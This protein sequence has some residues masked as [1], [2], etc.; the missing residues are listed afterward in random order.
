MSELR[1]LTHIN[2]ISASQWNALWQNTPDFDQNPFIR[3]EFLLALE[4]SGA[5]V[6]SNG[7]RAN[8]ACYWQE[9]ELLAVM[10]LYEKNHSYG[11]YVF[12]WSWADA[13]HQYGV[14]YY[15]KWVNAI[16]FTPSMGPRI[17]V[18]NPT[19]N[20][21]AM[22]SQEE[23]NRQQEITE[24]F[25]ALLIQASDK[26]NCSGIHCLFPNKNSQSAYASTVG[27][28][29]Q[30]F[31]TQFHWFN[32][33]YA[34]FDDF[35]GQL[36]SRKRKNIIKE[37]K[38]VSQSSLCIRMRDAK[39]ISEQEWQRFFA[40]YQM[41][42]LKRSGHPGYLNL[43][44]FLSLAE[45][46]SEQVLMVCAYDGDTMAAAALY[47]R[48]Q[49]TLYGRYWGALEQY[50]GLHFECCYY[51]GIEYAI[52]H[53]LQRF[54]PGAQGEHKIQRGFTPVNTCSY[55]YIAHPEFKTAINRFLLDE[56][57]HVDSYIDQCRALLPF[58]QGV[59]FMDKSHLLLQE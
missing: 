55:H 13:F 53:Q 11:E 5:C 36:A 54:D 14:P 34:N 9:K 26:Q 22:N 1:F 37:R 45:N 46:L 8:H 43:D 35:L 39:D 30:R 49:T 51:Q 3:H 52:S 18:A 28:F 31:G 44:F 23:M 4:N 17:A 48:D 47:L 2:E 38:K 32:Q 19:V 59:P 57:Q 15:P 29:S 16:P 50:D 25:L 40:L 7:W 58:K 12:D 10:P 42:Y 27:H 56:Q 20:R 6:Q 33:N 24:R 41:T 21:L